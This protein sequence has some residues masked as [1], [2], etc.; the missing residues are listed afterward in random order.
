MNPASLLLRQAHPSLVR[1][2]VASSAVFAPR[3]A[4]AG[5]LSCDD[6]DKITALEAWQR[7]SQ[8][9]RTRSAGVLAIAVLECTSLQLHVDPDGQ[10][11]P[12]HVSVVFPDVWTRGQQESVSKKL[13]DYAVSRGWQYRPESSP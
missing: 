5:R 11:N 12:E 2:G 4:D 1:E 7:F 3:R 10:P 9:D 6:G 8:G 13:R